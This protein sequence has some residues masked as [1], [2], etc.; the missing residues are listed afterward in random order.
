MSAFLLGWFRLIWLFTR[1]NEALVLEN[2]ALRQQLADYKRNSK[3]TQ[4]NRSDQVFGLRWQVCGRAGDESGFWYTQIQ[5]SCK[6]ESGTAI[7]WQTGDKMEI[8]V[9]KARRERS[10]EEAE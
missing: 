1:G 9:K 7:D 6:P 3:R 2:L 5:L 8:Q 4:L 10:R